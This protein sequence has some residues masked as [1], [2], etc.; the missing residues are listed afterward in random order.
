MALVLLLATGG[1]VATAL[2]VIP[3]ATQAVRA[4]SSATVH[5]DP[6]AAEADA[7][8]ESEGGSAGASAESGAGGSG[9]GAAEPEI[10]VGDQE[11]PRPVDP[12]DE[13]EQ[14]LAVVPSEKVK[15][16]ANDPIALDDVEVEVVD[17]PPPW[18]VH[19]LTPFETV[20]QI[21]HRYDVSP[22]TLRSWNGLAGQVDTL[23]PGTR[24]KLKA[25][26][27][28]PVRETFEYVV[29]PGDSWWSIAVAHAI[30]SRELRAAN[31]GESPGLTAGQTIELWVDPVVFHWVQ[32]D[33]RGADGG[34]LLAT[35]RRGAV[36]VGRP[37]SGRLINGVQIPAGEGWR[38]KVMAASYGTTYAVTNLVAALQQFRETSGAERPLL[39]G[40]MSRRH[41][42]PLP[43][44]RSHQ[45]GR[46]IDIRLPLTAEHPA[47]FPIKPW[48]VDYEVLWALVMAL[49]D[50]GGVSVIFLDYEL[51]KSLHEAALKLEVEEA[52]RR[53]I[54]Q[55]PQGRGADKGLVR[56][57]DGHE[58]HMQVRFRC[59]PQETECVSGGATAQ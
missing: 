59:G 29:Q 44:H 47:W 16:P 9:E 18:I 2:F 30:D 10:P 52:V 38:R 6:D 21:A 45:T 7:A 58:R 46:E 35:L 57:A 27:V 42:G 55:W 43:G 12:D 11:E 48:R 5:T 51:Q 33:R 32:T 28:P 49:S 1:G 4:V 56:H 41:G 25:R 23:G 24:L 20:D 14:A 17:G 31:K 37:E 3:R 19:R 13:I 26:R 39:L 40:A 53:R 22:K 15:I 8:A 50:T 36:G 54:I 34:D